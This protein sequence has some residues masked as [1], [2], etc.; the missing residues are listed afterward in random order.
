M[1]DSEEYSDA[2]IIEIIDNSS[3]SQISYTTANNSLS[4]E[5][6]EDNTLRTN[7]DITIE[8]SLKDS[9][10]YGLPPLDS[11]LEWIFFDGPGNSQVSI[12]VKLPKHLYLND[13]IAPNRTAIPLENFLSFD[14]KY[15][16]P[17]NLARKFACF[18]V[19]ADDF[20]RRLLQSVIPIPTDHA[21]CNHSNK[22]FA[23]PLFPS[24]F[25]MATSISISQELNRLVKL[26]SLTSNSSILSTG[27][28]HIIST[29]NLDGLTLMKKFL[30]KR[31][32]LRSLGFNS[33]LWRSDLL[34]SKIIEN[35]LH[36]YL[37]W[38]I[39]VT[40]SINGFPNITELK[41]AMLAKYLRIFIYDD[42]I[43]PENYHRSSL[44]FNGEVNRDTT[45]R[46]LSDFQ[47]TDA[48]NW[49]EIRLQ[50]NRCSDTRFGVL[51]IGSIVCLFH[52]RY[53]SE[54]NIIGNNVI[55]QL[56]TFNF[57]KDYTGPQ[58]MIEL[59]LKLLMLVEIA[60]RKMIY[61]QFKP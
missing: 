39:Q 55:K 58:E 8:L 13:H 38:T 20:A 56:M 49:L 15:P 17:E 57:L 36:R 37:D 43:D 27:Y 12:I 34:M 29:L 30:Q 44:D 46:Q 52:Y 53:I 60:T 51:I 10:F 32:T 35:H 25:S 18:P 28:N 26:Q 9:K 3:L 16:Q 19:N 21:S 47:I 6:Q 45:I 59:R 48:V 42:I 14:L 54:P 22:Q 5:K 50:D 40:A 1:S 7:G 33:M 24:S 31:R 23:I 4:A 61:D 41:Q 2:E 11:I